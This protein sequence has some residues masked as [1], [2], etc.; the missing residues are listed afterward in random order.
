MTNICQGRDPKSMTVLEIGCGAGRITRALTE[1]FGEVYAV[2]VSDE[3]I[4]IART[5]LADRPN[6]HLY[7]NNGVDL[8]VLPQVTFDFA[9]SYIVF[10]HI[11]S[12][13]VIESYV[14]EV[15]RV[16][17]PG[18]LF[19]FQ[20]QGGRH[21]GGEDNTWT[22]YSFSEDDSLDLA[23]RCSFE[24]RYRT[25]SGEQYFWHWF[26]KQPGEVVRYIVALRKYVLTLERTGAAVQIIPEMSKSDAECF[27]HHYSQQAS[28]EAIYKASAAEFSAFLEANFPTSEQVPPEN[29]PTLF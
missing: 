3:M 18:A 25:G 1:V 24:P 7:A 23:L 12:L 26:F 22:G 20:V 15:H 6:A 8:S 2:D 13:F 5:A 10:Q 17:R 16:L 14:R 9:F 11:P 29:H 27:R 4:K 19:K 21:P 28:A